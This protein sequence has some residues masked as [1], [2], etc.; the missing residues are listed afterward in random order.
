MLCYETLPVATIKVKTVQEDCPVHAY[1]LSSTWNLKI[2]L[3]WKE[4][5]AEAKGG[6]FPEGLIS[7]I[8]KNNIGSLY[9]F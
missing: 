8:G 5:T 3:K 9:Y 7:T 1:H 6:L 2:A 4:S